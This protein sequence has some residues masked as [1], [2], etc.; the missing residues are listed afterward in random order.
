MQV[1]TLYRLHSHSLTKKIT[2]MYV[3]VVRKGNK[4]KVTANDLT[5]TFTFLGFY[6]IYL[7]R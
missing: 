2:T 5:I 7:S 3:R 6:E 1:V 4:K